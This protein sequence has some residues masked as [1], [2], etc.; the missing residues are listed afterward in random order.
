[1]ANQIDL[2]LLV[3]LIND[4]KDIETNL[5]L[6][7]GCRIEAEDQAPL[8]KVINYFMNYLQAISNGAIQI[9]LDLMGNSCLMSLI[10]YTDKDTIPEFSS[11]L[12]DALKMYNA[13]F[14]HEH[15]VGS[16]VQIKIHFAK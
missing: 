2:K 9:S 7:E 10:G 3:Q 15:K 6:D 16:Y 11:N 13:K 8:V 12:N 5:I 4:Q 14:E 1:M